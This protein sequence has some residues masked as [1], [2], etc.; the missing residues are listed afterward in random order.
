MEETIERDHIVQCFMLN[1]VMLLFEGVQNKLGNEDP[2]VQPSFHPSPVC[3]YGDG[4]I[5]GLPT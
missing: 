4:S 2:V 1:N 5:R 3:L